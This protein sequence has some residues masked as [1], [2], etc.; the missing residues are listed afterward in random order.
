MRWS[1]CDG[2]FGV[3]GVGVLTDDVVEGGVTVG[4]VGGESVMFK[5]PVPENIFFF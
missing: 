1:N 4:R 3:A 5:N 2:L